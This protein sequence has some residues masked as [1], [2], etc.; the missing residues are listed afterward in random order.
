M[1]F[2]NPPRWLQACCLTADLLDIICRTGGKKT[3]T[4]HWDPQA[5]VKTA[6]DIG[7]VIVITFASVCV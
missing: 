3:T 4:I 7:K 6:K 1:F 2:S 5:D